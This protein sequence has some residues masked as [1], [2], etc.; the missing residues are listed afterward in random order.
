MNPDQAF[1]AVLQFLRG[2]W[3]QS[4][5][6]DEVGAL[7]TFCHYT[8]GRG[9]ADPAMWFDWLAQVK[10]VQS[11]EVIPDPRRATLTPEMMQPLDAEQAYLAMI[12]FIEEYWNRVKQPADLS[13]LL[14]RMRYLPGTGAADASLWKTWL[15][16]LE[17]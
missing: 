5:H 14:S 2:Y 16:A 9:T 15:A 1:R 11:G 10:R 4:G 8:P 13:D 7:L 6:P 17:T 3:D 12:A